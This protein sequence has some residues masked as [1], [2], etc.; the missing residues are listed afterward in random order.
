[1]AVI[2]SGPISA[3]LTTAAGAAATTT[4]GTATGK[5]S[6]KSSGANLHRHRPSH[7]TRSHSRSSSSPSPPPAPLIKP[8]AHLHTSLREKRRSFGSRQA[9]SQSPVPRGRTSSASERGQRERG[10]QLG[11]GSS[12]HSPSGRPL[13]GL[14]AGGTFGHG[15]GVYGY[16][17]GNA[18]AG[19]SRLGYMSS[20]PIPPHNGTYP[21]ESPISV[22]TD[23]FS[24]T[25]TQYG[26]SAS[27]PG[28]GSES[29]GE[30]YA[31]RANYFISARGDETEVENARRRASVVR[32]DAGSRSGSGD[33]GASQKTQTREDGADIGMDGS[34]GNG[35]AIDAAGAIRYVPQPQTHRRS[36]L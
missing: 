21:E 11:G 6:S 2:T 1:M 15:Q 16:D 32:T 10:W 33:G 17:T 29:E 28:A 8:H 14:G 26:A 31:H 34:I 30:G 24:T 19:P 12:G 7:R 4:N 5:P 25:A 22:M 18:H 20:A 35:K 36:L 13:S 3:A 27:S 23:G 9:Q